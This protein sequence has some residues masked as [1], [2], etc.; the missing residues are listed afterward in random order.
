MN[1][2]KIIG[3]FLGGLVGDVVGSHVEGK[4][5]E[6][7]KKYDL[8]NI[9][10]KRYTDDTEMSVVLT[11]HLLKNK[12]DVN[13]FN[14]HTEFSVEAQANGF[15]GYTEATRNL[16]IGFLSGK[17]YKKKSTANGCLMRIGVLGL[18]DRE[19]AMLINNIK[20]SIEYTHGSFQENVICCFIHCKVL[21][22]I[23][24]GIDDK[25]NILYSI[26]DSSKRC[27]NLYLRIKVLVDCLQNNKEDINF[28]LTGFTDF[29]QIQCMDLFTCAYYYI[30]KYWNTPQDAVLNCIRGGGDTDT[31][32]KIV[33]EVMGALHGYSWI[34]PY[35]KNLE[36]EKVIFDMAVDTCLFTDK[37]FHDER[38]R[39]K[40]PKYENYR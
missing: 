16:F 20:K 12:G 3:F 5:K 19:D 14:L 21:D 6:E 24:K 9:T 31:I 35:W 1:P 37:Y 15:R 11:R 13:S 2:D 38:Y 32:A 28:E 33:G 39:I 8:I 30:F 18:F 26:L 10:S 40:P 27:G 34:P 22:C 17:P 4:T 7:I 25:N 36:N 29:F 23:L